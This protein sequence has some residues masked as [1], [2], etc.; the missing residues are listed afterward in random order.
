M[1]NA[2]FDLEGTLISVDVTFSFPRYCLWKTNKWAWLKLR[3]REVFQVFGVRLEK[4]DYGDL[5]WNI[6][7][8]HL[9]ADQFTK[10]MFLF[11]NKD[12]ILL[13]SELRDGGCKI[14]LVTGAWQPLATVFA[15]KFGIDEA[16]GSTLESDLTGRK[17][18]VGTSDYFI[19]DNK[20]DLDA[21]RKSK[22]PI[23]IVWNKED[24][25]WWKERDIETKYI[26]P[27]TNMPRWQLWFPSL[28]SM[29]GGNRGGGFIR[30]FCIRLA[31]PIIGGLM[32]THSFI[33]FLFALFAFLCIYEVGYLINDT[34]AAKKNSILLI[35]LEK[36]RQTSFFNLLWN[37]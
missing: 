1:S 22:H 26:H 4:K 27:A 12:V 33:N 29:Y 8:L 37:A 35:V 10:K 17:S 3:I 34:Y 16:H 31:V 9:L 2:I 5:I 28:Y 20:D 14:I 19:S 25:G 7:N 6:P 18:F 23:A 11:K 21:M 15:R 36:K 30:F 24:M 32:L 13:I